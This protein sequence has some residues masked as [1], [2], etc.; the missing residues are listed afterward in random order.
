MCHGT[1]S[2]HAPG[3]VHSEGYTQEGIAHSVC[4][5]RVKEKEGEKETRGRLAGM[6][7]GGVG[8]CNFLVVAPPACIL[9]PAH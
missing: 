5:R 7:V 4:V 1:E 3:L 8:G 2:T 6:E 9:A